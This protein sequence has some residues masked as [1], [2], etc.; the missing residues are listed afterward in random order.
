VTMP[1]AQRRFETLCIL[2]MT[3]GFCA[4]APC[5]SVDGAIGFP[6]EYVPAMQV[7]AREVDTLRLASL[8]TRQD[9]TH[10]RFELPAGRYVFFAIPDEPGAPEIYG[11]HTFYSD[12]LLRGPKNVCGDHTLAVVAVSSGK[13]AINVKLDDWFL[14]DETA[15]DLDRILGITATPSADELGAPHFSEYPIARLA[16]PIAPPLAVSPDDLSAEERNEVLRAMNGGPNFAGHVTVA[17]V[18]CGVSC[19]HV[20]LVDWRSGKLIPKGALPKLAELPCRSAEAARFRRDSRLLSITRSSDN[21]IITEYFVWKP[22]SA[23]LTQT[24]E[25][26]RTPERFCAQPAH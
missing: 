24:A 18:G 20:L 21:A 2:S 7:Y 15:D 6:S 19:S 4:N 23:S 17:Q 16:N 8:A 13:R 5:A 9:Q 26:R 11:A 12:C 25:Y 3:A 10:F 14:P 22:D 1:A